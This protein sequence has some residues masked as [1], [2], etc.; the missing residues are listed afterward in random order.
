MPTT[1]NPMIPPIPNLPEGCIPA[2]ITAQHKDR[3]EAIS[4]QGTVHAQCKR[5]AYRKASPWDYPT[6]GDLVALEY[7]PDGDS[8]IHATLPR[9]SYF[10]RRA[11]GPVS[12]Q[13]AVAAN[14]DYVLLLASCNQDF[15]LPRL[16]RYLSQAFSSGGEPVILLTKADLV[17][18]PAPLV[19]AAQSISMGASVYAISVQT[20]KGLESL[21]RYLTPDKLLVLLGS[22]GVGKS[23]L[24]NAL[25]GQ[26]IMT[27]RAIR[28]DDAKGRHTT[29]HRQL[30]SLP[31]G[32]AIID[33][34]GMR[35]LGLWDAQEG[36]RETFQ[37]IEALAA[38]CRYRDCTHSHEPGCAL[39]EAVQA[40]LLSPQRLQSY[41]GLR[42]ESRRGTERNHAKQSRGLRPQE[43]PRKK[44]RKE[45]LE[46]PS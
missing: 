44:I 31:G 18:D 38:Q 26:D 6:V 13:Q 16:E 42:Q 20:G 7:R 32:A 17:P 45:D 22:S 14:F 24:V 37:D 39:R 10:V 30:L 2:R 12:M 27:V 25:M 1:K 21:S 4:A 41:Q 46:S 36:L 35:E 23:S 3:Y 34:P 40:G 28:E 15:N 19:E 33:T 8:L 43:G 11:A 9:K 5:A 29:T